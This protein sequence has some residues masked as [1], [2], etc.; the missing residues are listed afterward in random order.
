MKISTIDLVYFSATYT[1]RKI[2]RQ[3]AKQLG[4]EIKEHDITKE[5][6]K[7]D[8]TCDSDDLLVMGMPV[9]AG[10]IPTTTLKILENLKGENTPAIIVCVYGNRDYDDALLEMKNLVEEKGFKVISAA[11]FVAQHSIFPAV[12][13]HRPDQED[14]DKI[15]IFTD[16]S[17]ESLRLFTDNTS[18]F[19][20]IKVKGNIPYKIP[21]A[22]PLKP[23]GNRKCDKCGIC[24]KL[25]P[26]SAIPADEPRKTDKEI[27]ISCGRCIVVCPQHARH[28]GGLIY[29]IGSRKF[30]NANSARKEPEFFFAVN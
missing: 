30:K 5:T 28:F 4:G 29:A 24:V 10:R 9:Y 2:V 25:C 23:K 18:S 19:P 26:V 22:V 12:G 11:A 8:W 3:I 15:K 1:T 27:C 7:I 21:G 13:S 16:K 20:D 6:S 14:L 17:A